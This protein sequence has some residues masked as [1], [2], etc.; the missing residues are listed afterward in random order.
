MFNKWGFFLVYFYYGCFGIVYGMIYGRK[1]GE[2]FRY[3]EFEFFVSIVGI[4]FKRKI[5]LV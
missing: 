3:I 4:G 2:N 5:K 1:I